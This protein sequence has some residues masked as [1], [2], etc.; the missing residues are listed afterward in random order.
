MTHAEAAAL[1][2]RRRRAWV[3][4]DVD[5]YLAL[6][7]PDV[8]F[9][10]PMHEPPLRGLEA[11]AAL[12]R[13]SHEMVRPVAFDIHHLAVHGHVILAEWTITAAR[14][15]DGRLVTWRGMSRCTMRDGLIVSWKEYWN[16]AELAGA[17]A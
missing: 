1:F 13:R 9:S 10:S 7:H 8:E 3:A 16:P 14:R 6:W 2:E 4:G 12:V 11:Y 15:T 17:G 5:A